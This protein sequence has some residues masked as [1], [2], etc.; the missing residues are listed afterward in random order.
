MLTVYASVNE[1]TFVNRNFSKQPLMLRYLFKTF[2]AGI[3]F[4]RQ[5]KIYN[6]EYTGAK[7]NKKKPTKTKENRTR[8][9]KPQ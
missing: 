6:I 7:Y 3:R 5:N 8:H 9:N 1:C 4:V 2:C